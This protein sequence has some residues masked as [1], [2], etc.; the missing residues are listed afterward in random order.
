MKARI[1]FIFLIFL[2]IHGF[3]QV[4]DKWRAGSAY[5]LSGKTYVLTVFISETE[6]AYQ[7]KKEIYDKIYEAEKWL[8]NQ[9]LVYNKKISFSGGNFG[10]N[11]TIKVDQIVVGTGSG[12][13]PTDLVSKVLKKI[14]YKS[15]MEFV[16]WVKKTRTATIL[17][18]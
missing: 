1:I 7:E 16:D 4:Q 6:W 3:G 9:A 17:W 18:S 10:L 11:K 5:S 2:S 15:N 12:N 14:G 13:E 8:T